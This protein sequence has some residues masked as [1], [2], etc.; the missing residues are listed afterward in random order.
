MTTAFPEEPSRFPQPNRLSLA[1]STAD[2]IAEAIA[3]GILPP[4]ARVTEQGAGAEFGVSRVTMREALK[5]LHAQGLLVGGTHRGFRVAPFSEGT[6]RQVREVRLELEIILLRDALGAWRSG[7]ASRRPLVAALEEMRRCALTGDMRGA[8]R[9]DVSFHRAIRDAA[10]NPI[11]GPLWD[12]IA[13]HTLI[14]F[15]LERAEETD[16]GIILRQHEPFL[17]TIDGLVATPPDDAAL[18][19]VM[20]EHIILLGLR[21]P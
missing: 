2:A 15:N 20:W 18:R 8:L 6:T 5:V 12:A 13:R 17:A 9:A 3:T 14:I 7:A 4:G 16:P 21:R 10:G 19:R 1:D 11:V